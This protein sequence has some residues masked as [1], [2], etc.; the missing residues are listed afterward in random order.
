MARKTNT[1]N[2]AKKPP[3]DIT[4][5]LAGRWR[6]LCRAVFKVFIIF[7]L[8]S[9]FVV[10]LFRFINPPTNAYIVSERWRLGAVKREWIDIS[11]LPKHVPRSIVAAEDANFCTH[12][13]FDFDQIRSALSST[14]RK[15][16]A[17]TISQ[18]V[19]KNVFLWQ[20]RS[21]VR[22]G[23]EVG[24]TVLIELLWSKERII[25]VYINVAEFDEGVFG[26]GA[27]AQHYFGVKPERITRLQAAR[28]AAI[29]PNPK[30]RSAIRPSAYTRKR[31]GQILSG[32]ETIAADGR[33]SCFL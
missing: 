29:L 25:E 7:V 21:W 19:A 3:R 23:F 9:A 26:V 14:G 33:A 1:E 30:K 16:G 11:V 4:A 12:Y 18:Q 32:E 13:G 24:F 31:T 10:L 8:I 20:G 15:R 5:W 27:A 28:L 22:K 2:I 6:K 17:S